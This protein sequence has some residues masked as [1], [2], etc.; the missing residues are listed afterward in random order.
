MT[1]ALD[2]L[3]SLM[4]RK[5]RNFSLQGNRGRAVER[6]GVQ[7]RRE[8]A[9]GP[10]VAALQVPSRPWRR[11]W[12]QPS[13]SATLPV[14][15]TVSAA[16]Q[17]AALAFANGASIPD[18]VTQEFGHWLPSLLCRQRSAR[19]QSVSNNFLDREL[20]FY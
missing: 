17:N 8:Q 19:S 6:L 11:K 14:I 12:T 16:Q 4:S 10:G 5:E 15:C 1:P 20:I 3:K 7:Q 18:N 9:H 13:G 2:F